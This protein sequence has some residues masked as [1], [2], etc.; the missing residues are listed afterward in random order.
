MDALLDLDEYCI[1]DIHGRVLQQST[2]SLTGEYIVSKNV[3]IVQKQAIQFI[4][5]KINILPTSMIQLKDLD[6]NI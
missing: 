1:T 5:N 6:T 4:T 2:K 3:W